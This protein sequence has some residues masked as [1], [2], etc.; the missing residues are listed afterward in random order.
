MLEENALLRKAFTDA[1]KTQEGWETK[2]EPLIKL[3]TF[4]RKPE[5]YTYNA[6]IRAYCDSGLM[7]KSFLI[8]ERMRLK[9]IHRSSFTYNTLFV[10]MS[11]RNYM[12]N[13]FF[14][15]VAYML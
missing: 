7:A 13:N 14:V 2:V 9:R 3:K 15:L 4:K 6:L 11:K 5:N 1:L 10:K 12:M 8:F